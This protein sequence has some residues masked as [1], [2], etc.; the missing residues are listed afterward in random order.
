MPQ[1]FKSKNICFVHYKYIFVGIIT[2][3]HTLLFKFGV[4][5]IIF[6]NVFAHQGCVYLIQIKKNSHFMK[7][8]YNFKSLFE[9]ILKCNLLLWCKSEFSGSVL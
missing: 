6:F 4:S 3:H 2:F 8:Y 7:Y 1:W 5:K 9:Y